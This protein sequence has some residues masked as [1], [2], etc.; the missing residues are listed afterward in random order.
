MD[1]AQA[2]ADAAKERWLTTLR[3]DPE[4]AAAWNESVENLRKPENMKPMVDSAVRLFE[5]LK[6]L[7]KGGGR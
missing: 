1:D 5:V 3:S 4:L 6:A 7:Q 2:R